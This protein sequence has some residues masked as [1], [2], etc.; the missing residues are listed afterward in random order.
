MLHYTYMT[1]SQSGRYYVGRHSTENINDGYVGSG[2][3]VR[4]IKDK[5]SLTKT[6]IAFYDSFE[7]VLAAE[8]ALIQEHLGKDLCMNFNDRPVG[9]ASGELNP[10][11]REEQK[12][13]TRQRLLEDNPSRRED[14]RAKKSLIMKGRPAVGKRAKGWKMTEEERIKHSRAKSG[15]KFS[16]EG[17]RKLSES[18]K[19][20]FAAGERQAPSFK[21]MQ[22]KEESKLLVSKSA[23]ERSKLM[24]PHCGGEAKPH[25]YKRWHGDNCKERTK[26]HSEV[27]HHCEGR[28]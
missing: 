11:V 14:V 17:R 26:R 27:I 1:E 28:P 25:T 19:K 12:Q 23:L 6:I 5:S 24:C 18:R 15:I 8:A 4:S 16:D 22:H 10:A 9:F 3:W 21:G 13:S 20:Q 7:E 2:K